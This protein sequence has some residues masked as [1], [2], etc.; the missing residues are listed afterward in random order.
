MGSATIGPSRPQCQPDDPGWLVEIAAA[1]RAVN[2]LLEVKRS[3]MREDPQIEQLLWSRHID[4]LRQI[5]RK[6]DAV[7]M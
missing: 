4:R 2:A 3:A 1:E 6:L 7:C 5:K